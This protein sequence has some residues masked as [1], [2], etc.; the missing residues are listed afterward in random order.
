ML[1]RHVD[2]GGLI[3]RI[4]DGKG[5]GAAKKQLI[6]ARGAAVDPV[7]AALTGGHGRHHPDNVAQATRDLMDV[8]NGI[9][10]RKVT[11]LAEALADGNPAYAAVIFAIGHS[12]SRHARKILKD[13]LD[14]PDP[15]VAAVANYHLCRSKRR[16]VKKKA[17]KTAKK[18]VTKKAK[19]K[20]KRKPATKR[21]ATRKPRK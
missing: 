17:K 12:R 16:P 8:L 21:R 5:A 9:A 7:L 10:R 20:V 15:G 18:K 2:I 3:R 6:A 14:H 11:P 4:M 13:H 1:R 19:K